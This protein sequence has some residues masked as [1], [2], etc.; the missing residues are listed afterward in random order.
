ECVVAVVDQM[1]RRFVPGKGISHLSREPF[2]G[3]IVRHADA[4]QSP[5]GVAPNY[6]AIEQLEGES[7]NHEQIDRR[8]TRS[9]IAQEYL[10]ALRAGPCRLVRYLATVDSATSIPSISSSLCIRGA[11]HSGFSL[12]ICRMRSRISRSILGR[13][14][15]RRDFQRQY[16][17]KPRRCQPI[18]VSGLTTVMA[19][20]IDGNS[21]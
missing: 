21:R 7:A 14:P 5:S 19:F 3:R 4:H 9:V 8:D 12:F 11:P 16:A 2:G 15:R 13:P 6:Q 1:T 20:K 17:R 10:P 18:T